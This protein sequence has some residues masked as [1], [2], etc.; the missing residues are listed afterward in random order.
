MKVLHTERVKW[1]LS[2]TGLGHAPVRY[3]LAE[4]QQ[5]KEAQDDG[6]SAAVKTLTE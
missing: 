1:P 2:R 6:E 4:V 3:W 5:R